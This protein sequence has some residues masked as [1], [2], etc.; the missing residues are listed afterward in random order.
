MRTITKF[1]YGL[2]GTAEA[3]AMDLKVQ[4]HGRQT[5]EFMATGTTTR[6]TLKSV[7]SHPTTGKRAGLLVRVTLPGQTFK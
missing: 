2:S 7:F 5:W 1:V 6:V 4:E 3:H